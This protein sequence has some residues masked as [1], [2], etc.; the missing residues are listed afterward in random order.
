[1]C[2]Y[3]YLH[4]HTHT[5]KWRRE[6]SGTATRRRR[7]KHTPLRGLPVTARPRAPGARF[8]L[9]FVCVFVFC[10]R[11]P[12][13]LSLGPSPRPQTALRLIGSLLC[14][15]LFF[16]PVLRYTLRLARGHRLPPALDDGG[17]AGAGTA[18]Q[19]FMHTHAHTCTHMHTHAYI[20]IY[21]Y[22]HTHTPD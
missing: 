10:I 3:I 16:A 13:E 11:T 4:T 19:A 20:Y 5:Y 18:A 2:V 17:M 6:E 14:S 22:T 9:G 7:Y 8:V 12:R 21:I 1:M 15:F